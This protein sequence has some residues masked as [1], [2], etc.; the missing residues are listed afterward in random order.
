V[1]KRPNI[2]FGQRHSLRLKKGGYFFVLVGK[3]DNTKY[4]IRQPFSPKT[5]A[6]FHQNS[7]FAKK[8][9]LSTFE[10]VRKF[11]VISKSVSSFFIIRRCRLI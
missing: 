8:T 1:P 11:I 7:L 3:Q 5:G 10:Y 9:F 6:I 2:W 4:L